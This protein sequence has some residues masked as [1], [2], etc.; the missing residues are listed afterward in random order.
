MAPPQGA[1]ARAPVVVAPPKRAAPL[2]ARAAK[3]AAAAPP[4][5]H[6]GWDADVA[7]GICMPAM[8]TAHDKHRKVLGSIAILESPTRVYLTG[9]AKY[10]RGELTLVETSAKFKTNAAGAAW[11]N[12]S[13]LAADIGTI[14]LQRDGMPSSTFGVAIMPHIDSGE[15]ATVKWVT[16]YWCVPSFEGGNMKQSTVEVI[17]T[18]NTGTQTLN[19]PCMVHNMDVKPG[20]Q[21]KLN[22]PP[23]KG[24]MRKGHP[25]C[26]V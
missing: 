5:M 25:R 22:A 17:L 1:A 19:A 16:Q 18:D 11:A 4:H 6:D 12:Q 15:K 3:K 10:K 13:M 14:T 2:V 21:L 20:D 7:V 9:D 23:K 24:E 8:R 26:T